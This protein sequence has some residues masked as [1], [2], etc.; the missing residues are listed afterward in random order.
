[1]RMGIEADRGCPHK[2]GQRRRGLFHREDHTR[3]DR[4]DNWVTMNKR[5]LLYIVL[6]NTEGENR[7][8]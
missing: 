3:D 6:G 2:T 7:S 4:L 8:V 1:M 5:K